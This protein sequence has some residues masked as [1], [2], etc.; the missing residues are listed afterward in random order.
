VI[1]DVDVVVVVVVVGDEDE[2]R[3][4]HVT[5]PMTTFVDHA[6]HI[7]DEDGGASPTT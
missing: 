4:N 7:R 2:D 6:D 5:S 3:G 1:V